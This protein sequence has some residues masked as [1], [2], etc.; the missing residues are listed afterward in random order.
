VK[1]IQI[2][3]LKEKEVQNRIPG[4]LFIEK[5]QQ[6]NSLKRRNFQL[7]EQKLKKQN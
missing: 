5:P 2:I 4:K 3:D 6:K 7:K 1:I